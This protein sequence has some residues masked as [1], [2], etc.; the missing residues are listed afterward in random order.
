MGVRY[1][2][3]D[4]LA[5]LLNQQLAMRSMITNFSHVS[6]KMHLDQLVLSQGE[7]ILS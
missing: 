5:A 7:R 6:S 1:T 2:I 4:D 3:L